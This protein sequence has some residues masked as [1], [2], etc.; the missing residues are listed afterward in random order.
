MALVTPHPVLKEARVTAFNADSSGAT[1]AYTYAP[2]RGRIVKLGS[3]A[4][5][6]VDSDRLITAKINGTAITGGAVTL[7]ASGSAAGDVH[8]WVPTALNL[9]NEDDTIEFLSDGAG[10]TACPHQFFALIQMA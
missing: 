3:V 1:S 10:G 9:V 4:G 7:T 6:A 8:T 5:A 2:F